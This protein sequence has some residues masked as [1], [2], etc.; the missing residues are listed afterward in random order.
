MCRRRGR[1]GAAEVPAAAP[2]A[3]G[4]R[5]SAVRT[6]PAPPQ[7]PP[8]EDQ[9]VI[10]ATFPL[11]RIQDAYRRLEEGHVLGKIVLLP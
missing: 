10:E 1:A 5:Y 6:R 9:H 8:A 7:A 2:G 3:A 11:D 4:G